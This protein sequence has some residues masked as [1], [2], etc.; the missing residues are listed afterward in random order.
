MLRKTYSQP[1]KSWTL[2]NP[3]FLK[4]TS[5]FQ[6]SFCTLHQLWLGLDTCGHHQCQHWAKVWSSR[7]RFGG[8]LFLFLWLFPA[9]G[10]YHQLGVLLP[11]GGELLK[12]YSRATQDFHHL[13]ECLACRRYL[14]NFSRRNQWDKW[15]NE[16]YWWMNKIPDKFIHSKILGI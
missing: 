13:E 1:M 4:S 2:G 8:S 15:K 12:G 5:L 3:V 6:G 14:I 11:T 16:K 9:F 10:S 7:V